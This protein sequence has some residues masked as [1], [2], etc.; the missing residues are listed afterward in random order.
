MAS[1]LRSEKGTWEPVDCQLHQLQADIEVTRRGAV[2]RSS[3]AHP[4]R[5]GKRPLQ[6]N[7]K[8]TG[9]VHARFFKCKRTGEYD[10]L[11]Q[12]LQHEAQS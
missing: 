12:I 7:A 4:W 11:S 10:G 1:F 3:L 5:R 8:Q 6:M 2:M 9:K